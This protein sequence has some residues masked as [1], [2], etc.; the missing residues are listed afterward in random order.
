MS[1]RYFFPLLFCA[2]LLL[3]LAAVAE[4]I[5][6]RAAN[7]TYSQLGAQLQPIVQGPFTI[8]VASPRHEIKVHANRLDLQKA[9]DP[10]TVDARFEVELEGFGDLI[11]D[12]VG[13][14]DTR[15]HFEERVTARRQRIRVA[16]SMRLQRVPQGYMWTL[17]ES[18]SPSI[19]F[20][21]ES[22]LSS[23]LVA[24]C[25]VLELLPIVGVIDCDALEKALTTI[26]VPMPAAG[27]Q[28]LV[29]PEKLTENEKK[30][31]DRFVLASPRP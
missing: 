26:K 12:V 4:T 9:R 23:K 11:A 19:D 5:E 20:V 24:T 28:W 8:T 31:L 7:G 1:N 30:F 14:N 22:G 27:T 17:V 3:P 18:Y 29:V 13:P 21:I 10:L 6:I 16:A 25:Q 2:F 15:S